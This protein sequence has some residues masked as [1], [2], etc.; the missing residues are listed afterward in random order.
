MSEAGQL[1]EYETQLADIEE[2]LQL[3]PNDESLLKLKLDL[4]ELIALTK[5]DKS[6]TEKETIETAGSAENY[7]S[8]KQEKHPPV[9]SIVAVTTE[10]DNTDVP[11][12][13]KHI[14]VKKKLKRVKAFEVPTQLQISETDSEKEMSRKKRAVKALKNKHREKQREYNSTKKQKSW[15]T[16]SQK[17]KGKRKNKSIFATQDGVKAKVGVVSGGS[18]TDFGERKRHKYI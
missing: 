11:H 8:D 9:A 5:D 3:D 15:Q 2:L 13:G 12:L 17:G 4:L 16:F 10:V 14:V 18:M 1:Q 6:V 7:L